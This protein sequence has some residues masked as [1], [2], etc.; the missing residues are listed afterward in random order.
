VN[1]GPKRKRDSDFLRRVDGLD[2][3]F[4]QNVVWGRLIHN[5]ATGDRL[6][7]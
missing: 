1:S 2:E 7:V 3:T 6:L 4:I 5:R